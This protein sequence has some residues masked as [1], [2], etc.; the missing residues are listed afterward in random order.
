MR[1][2]YGK[3]MCLIKK[4]RPRRKKV[5]GCSVTMRG[6][7]WLALAYVVAVLVCTSACFHI[8]KAYYGGRTVVI[9]DAA[10]A[11]LPNLRE[12]AALGFAHAYVMPILVVLCA[13]RAGV[14]A[15]YMRR[16]V[17]ALLVRLVLT[18]LTVLPDTGECATERLTF[19]EYVVGHC[20]DKMPSGHFI[21]AGTLLWMLYKRGSLSATV[22]LLVAAA[23]AACILMLRHHYTIDVAGGAMLILV[24]D[25]IADRV[26]RGSA[27]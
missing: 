14:L 10:H 18:T 13:A 17:A 24:V 19:A 11:V 27:W 5:W 23:V 16:T 21:V 22:A 26:A 4:Q 25:Q 2:A 1:C 8:G 6:D 12:N 20:Y 3:K 15:P 9:F 7:V